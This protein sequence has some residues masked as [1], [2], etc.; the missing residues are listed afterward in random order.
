MARNG[1]AI[2]VKVAR[3]KVIKALKDALANTIKTYEAEEKAQKVYDKDMEAYNKKVAELA[4][5]QITKAECVRVSERWNGVVNVDFNLPAGA[6]KM[7]T[8]PDRPHRTT[9]EYQYIEQ[10]KEMEN[11]IRILEMSDEE[12]ISTSTYQAV[13]QYL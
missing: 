4:L 9:S 1:K 6:V 11:A 5:K 3:V 12:L 8:E 2:N 13:A 7:P 10:K